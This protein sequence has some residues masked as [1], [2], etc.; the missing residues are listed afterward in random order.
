MSISSTSTPPTAVQSEK[1]ATSY[2]WIICGLLLFSTTINYMDRQVISYLK[3]PAA[4]ETHACLRSFLIQK[5]GGNT[6]FQPK[7]TSSPF[8]C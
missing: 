7:E 1:P 3:E 5:Q 2:R 8:H 6:D 4:L